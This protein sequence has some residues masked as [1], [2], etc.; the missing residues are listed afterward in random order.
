MNNEMKCAHCGGSNLRGG[1]VLSA[2]HSLRFFAEGRKLLSAGSDAIAIA[3]LDCGAVSLWT[4]PEKVKLSMK[5][6]SKE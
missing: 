5:A 3:C 4:D 1:S 2:I 6:E